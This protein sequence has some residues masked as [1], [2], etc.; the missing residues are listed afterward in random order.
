M[1][2]GYE[3]FAVSSVGLYFTDNIINRFFFFEEKINCIVNKRRIQKE[4]VKQV[5]AAYQLVQ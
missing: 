1:K 2:S 3:V 4:S 5:N